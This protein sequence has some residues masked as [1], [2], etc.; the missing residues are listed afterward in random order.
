MIFGVGMTSLRAIPGYSSPTKAFA[1]LVAASLLVCSASSSGQREAG[2]S[3]NGGIRS[4]GTVGTDHVRVG[5]EWWVAFPP[6]VNTSK[7]RLEVTGVKLLDV[8]KGLKVTEYRAVD[9]AESEGVSLISRQGDP[10]MPDITRLKDHSGR[11]IEV[12]SGTDSDIYFV[13][14]LKVTGPI[15]KNANGCQFEYE[16]DSKKYAQT[17]QCDTALRLERS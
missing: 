8:P 16:Q 2:H 13:A 11:P 3:L 10:D 9:S 1:A 12:N 17:L 4:N 6:V 15:S 5:E 14:R 7:Q